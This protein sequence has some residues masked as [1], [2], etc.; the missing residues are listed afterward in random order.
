MRK[1]NYPKVLPDGRPQQIKTKVETHPPP[2]SCCST[3][4]SSRIVSSPTPVMSRNM[5]KAISSATPVHTRSKSD[6][7]PQT[8][9]EKA[10][11][12]AIQSSDPKAKDPRVNRRA[13]LQRSTSI[14]DISDS[15]ESISSVQE[16]GA[17]PKKPILRST[18]NRSTCS[19]KFATPLSSSESLTDS[20]F[21]LQKQSTILRRPSDK[22]L[23]RSETSKQGCHVSSESL[24]DGTITIRK[25]PPS[26]SSTTPSSRSSLASTTPSPKSIQRPKLKTQLS[27][28]DNTNAGNRTLPRQVLSH[29]RTP[30]P[31]SWYAQYHTGSKSQEDPA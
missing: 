21:S 16:T 29:P 30:N 13:R 14:R 31:K 15:N 19:I 27:I 22:S 8:P 18:S 20:Q 3:D 7:Q 24:S 2:D 11:F 23:T 10:R 25:A 26:L 9:R 5:P 4:S 17:K 1:M 28:E 12:N 6:T